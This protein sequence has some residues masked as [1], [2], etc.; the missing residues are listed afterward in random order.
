MEEAMVVTHQA[1]T[2]P[3]LSEHNNF[4]ISAPFSTLPA[5]KILLKIFIAASCFLLNV[6]A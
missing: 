4:N 3:E 5:Q 2:V 1:T 6:T